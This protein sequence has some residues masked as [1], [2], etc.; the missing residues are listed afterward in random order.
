[1]RIALIESRDPGELMD[2]MRYL[3]DCQCPLWIGSQDDREFDASR[4]NGIAE[5]ADQE[6]AFDVVWLEGR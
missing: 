3:D 2:A 6:S 4:L 5:L 1:M